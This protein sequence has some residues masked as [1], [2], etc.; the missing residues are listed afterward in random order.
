MLG[1]LIIIVI[2]WILLYFIENKN[3][4]VLGIVPNKKR[5]V[6]FVIGLLFIAF[7]SLLKI[8]IEQLILKV[9]WQLNSHINY[10]LIFDAF[11][12][13]LRSALT[14]DLMYRGAILYILI[15]R[16]GAKWALLISAIFFGVYHVFSYGMLG[17]RIVPIA[18]IIL[19][20]GVTGYVWA[21]TF[22]KTKSIIMGLS[23]HLGSN[24]VMSFFYPSNPFGELLFTELSRTNFASEWNNLWFLLFNGLFPSIVTYIF[25]RLYTSEK[26][27]K[28]YSEAELS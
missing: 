5:S 18:Y 4:D 2:S 3:I 12:Y 8:F 13:H 15:Q 16:L 9:N 20:T 19:I 23:F 26:N 10:S 25:V 1:L 28:V 7:V 27:S 14:E 17:E 11:I 21:Y 6:Q 22:Y 24:L